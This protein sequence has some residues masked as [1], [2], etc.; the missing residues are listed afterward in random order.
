MI[1]TYAFNAKEF[2][3]E[4]GM[5]YYGARYYAPPTFISRDPLFEKY[6][7]ISP[8]AY[9]ANNPMKFVDPSGMDWYEGEDGAVTWTN[10]TNK[11][12]FSKSGIKGTYLGKTHTDSKG[13]YYSLF[14]D[15]MK[16]NSRN[17]KITQK[18]DNAFINYAKFLESSKNG[19]ASSNP[20]DAEVHDANQKSTDFSN[21]IPFND[22]FFTTSENKHGPDEMGKYAGVAD[23]YFNV[24]GSRMNGKF[25]NF[26]SGYVKTR[27]SG[28]AGTLSD[29]SGNLLRITNFKGNIKN[30]IVI[31]RLNS[32]ENVKAFENRF[33]QLFPNSR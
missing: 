12:E 3:E 30:Y 32:G 29:I 27:V 16:A 2:D 10:C 18:I 14:G 11:G 4:N 19:G 26:S 28:R 22:G 13:M 1:P 33:Y 21:V 25:E 15:K 9:C 20:Y 6:P 7:S 5:Y 23:I 24:T 31:L 17:G 8:Y